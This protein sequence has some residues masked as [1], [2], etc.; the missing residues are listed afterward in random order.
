MSFA[1]QLN[2][3]RAAFQSPSGNPAQPA[4]ARN[5]S[6]FGGVEDPGLE[7]DS[8]AHRHLEAYGAPLAAVHV[9][10]FDHN[11][12]AFVQV[13]QNSPAKVHPLL[14]VAFEA[15]HSLVRG[16]DPHFSGHCGQN[17]R[18]KV[19][20]IELRVGCESKFLYLS[21]RPWPEPAYW[22]TNAFGSA[23][24][25]FMARAASSSSACLRCRCFPGSLSRSSSRACSFC[26]SPGSVVCR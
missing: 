25:T 16:I 9:S 2:R 15:S 17:L 26:S 13:P 1:Q 22:Y 20:R 12:A 18:F 7:D 6:V 23:R 11:P 14:Q 10:L 8:A 3:W 21:R 24:S 4:R 19:W 5:E